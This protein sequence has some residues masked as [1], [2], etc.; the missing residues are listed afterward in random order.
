MPPKPT[1]SLPVTG[2]FLRHSTPERSTPGRTSRSSVTP[3]KH[4]L[5]SEYIKTPLLKEKV[6]PM[7]LR[8]IET[9]LLQDVPDLLPIIF[10]DECLPLSPSEILKQLRAGPSPLYKKSKWVGCP[11][12]SRPSFKGDVEAK[13]A[14]FLK[15]FGERAAALCAASGKPVPQKKRAWTSQFANTGVPDAPNTRKPD[16]FLGD[17][18]EYRWDNVRGHGE[19][20]SGDSSELRKDVLNQL[21]NGAYLIFSA[22]D[23]RRF[24]VSIAFMAENIRVF[25]F[26]RAGLVTTAP[27]HLH[28]DPEAFIRVMTALMFTTDLA[29]LGYDTSICETDDGRRHIMVAGVKYDIEGKALFISDVIR[30]RGTV[31]WRVRHEGKYF[32]IKDTWADDSRQYTEADILR[33]AAS[34]DGVPKVVADLIVKVNGAEGRTDSLRSHLPPDGKFDKI[35]SQIEKRVHHRVVLTPFGHT[36]PNFAS[37]KELISIFMDAVKAHQDLYEN[38]SILHR[39]I[40]VNNILLVP[41]DD[42]PT[43][44][45]RATLAGPTIDKSVHLAVVTS[46]LR[47]GLLIDMD[48]ALVLEDAS[49]SGHR[50]AAAGHRTG[51]LPFMST[52]V[53][54]KGEQLSQHEPRHDLESLLYV[55][56]W[57]CLHYAGPGNV[58]RHNF[59]INYSNL[60]SWVH[61]ETFMSIGVFK[62]GIMLD[63]ELWESL[64]LD[65]FAPYFEPLKSCASVWRELYQ[66]KTLTYTAVL[67][68]LKAA[69][70]SLSDQEDWSA[71]DDPAGYGPETKKRRLERIAEGDEDSDKDESR[72]AKY[73]RNANGE[74]VVH[75]EP[76]PVVLRSDDT[77]PSIT[78]SMKPRKTLPSKELRL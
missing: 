63:D 28:K 52:E 1:Y 17:D 67:E 18:P 24:V 75:S 25:I 20:K 69:L 31:C 46:G 35:Y 70:S 65:S 13:L 2:P 54:I 37:R 10:P 60:R 19:L 3:I 29:L 11:D 77:R 26:D 23:N 40:S 44:P 16:L 5:H 73:S 78:K 43:S 38:A 72:A 47:R 12:L 36:L 45:S 6:D 62:R 76:P 61:G 66:G 48:Y 9:S 15:T 55:L 30:G 71:K 58:E 59:D 33:K 49:A 22:Q 57:V 56:I 68:V 14:A 34:V 74:R 51:T 64:V 21:L 32:V 7:L 41:S 42:P 4:K 50:L 53:L 39:D 8:E 27:F